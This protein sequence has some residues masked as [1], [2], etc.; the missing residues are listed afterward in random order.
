[1]GTFYPYRIQ[2]LELGNID[3]TILPSRPAFLVFLHND[4]PLG[5]LWMDAGKKSEEPEL[6]DEIIRSISPAMNY[7]CN[8]AGADSDTWRSA[9]RGGDK[10]VIHSLLERYI[11]PPLPRLEGEMETDG[12]SVVICTRNR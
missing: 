1:M 11:R 10:R 12:L 9:L 5:H 7:Y 4:I 6:I 2:Y 8:E 3:V